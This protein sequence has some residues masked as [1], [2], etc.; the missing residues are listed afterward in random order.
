MENGILLLPNQGK[1]SFGA[2]SQSDFTI[3]KDKAR[4][5]RY[6]VEYK[7]IILSP[8]PCYSGIRITPT[9]SLYTF[10]QQ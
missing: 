9:L 10:V 3:H 4:K 1:E 6:I 5:Q 2:T 7:L 8:T